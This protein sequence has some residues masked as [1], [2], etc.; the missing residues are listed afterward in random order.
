MYKIQP[1]SL[2]TIKVLAIFFLT[3]IISYL[4]APMRG[5]ITDLILRSLIIICLFGGLVLVMNVSDDVKKVIDSGLKR[6]K[7]ILMVIRNRL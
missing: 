3:L 2:N 6:I 4:I 7:D 5:F 1:F